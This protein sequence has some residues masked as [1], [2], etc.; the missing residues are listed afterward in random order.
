MD[1]Y[2]Y[3]NVKTIHLASTPPSVRRS[4][5]Q[6]PP[7][8]EEADHVISQLTGTMKDVS[9]LPRG[10]KKAPAPP[11]CTSSFKVS[12]ICI[13]SVV[14]FVHNSIVNYLTL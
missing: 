9:V 10:V 12:P 1:L 2:D 14:Q 3:L 6:P 4:A 8:P 7:P 11:K 13:N 5:V